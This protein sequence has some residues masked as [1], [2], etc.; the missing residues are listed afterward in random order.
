MAAFGTDALPRDA[1]FASVPDRHRDEVAAALR[2][3]GLVV[4]TDVGLSEFKMDLAVALPEAPDV[5]VLAVL[6]DGPAWARRRTVGDR[7]G[8]PV[9]VLGRMLRWPAV[10]RVWLPS[11]LADADA[12]VDWLVAAAQAPAAPVLAAEPVPARSAAV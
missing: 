6:L 11:W 2:A 3:R 4:R 10:E 9:E 8:L 1:R 12:V 5:P 7:D